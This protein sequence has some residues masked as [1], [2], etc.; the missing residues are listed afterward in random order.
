MALTKE[1]IKDG[2]QQMADRG[3]PKERI[4][5]FIRKA[6]AMAQPVDVPQE[7]QLPQEEYANSNARW[8]NSGAVICR[9]AWASLSQW[10]QA[11]LPMPTKDR[12]MDSLHLPQNISNPRMLAFL[13]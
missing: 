11:Q 2:A 8:M 5:D 7:Q 1:Q 3:D 4:A 13:F 10:L 9:E 6:S 12:T